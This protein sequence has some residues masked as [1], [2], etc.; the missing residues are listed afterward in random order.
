MQPEVA[1]L[2]AADRQKPDE[3]VACGSL[4]QHI[5]NLRCQ[6]VR[7]NR[8]RCRATPCPRCSGGK[9]IGLLKD[10]GAAEE[11]QRETKRRET[12]L[13]RLRLNDRGVCLASPETLAWHTGAREIHQHTGRRRARGGLGCMRETCPAGGA[14]KDGHDDLCGPV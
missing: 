3:G 9:C 2:P 8:R 13:E 6:P 10:G 1:D 7:D 12:H 5:T 11:P 14:R 4:A